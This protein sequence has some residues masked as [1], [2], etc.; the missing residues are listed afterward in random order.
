MAK[1]TQTQNRQ[2]PPSASLSCFIGEFSQYLASLV[3]TSEELLITGNFNIHVDNVKNAD[4]QNFLNSLDE[5]G[6]KQ[7]VD[8]PT[9]KRGHILDLVI[10]RESNNLLFSKPEVKDSLLCDLRGNVSGDHKG[11]CTVLNVSKPEKPEKLVSSRQFREVNIKD[12][13]SDLDDT[14]SFLKLDDISLDDHVT[15]Y[16]SI[17]R[18]VVDKHAPLL[19]KEITLRP[20][21]KWYSSELRKAKREKRKVKGNKINNIRDELV[22]ESRGDTNYMAFDKPFEGEELVNFDPTTCE[23]VLKILSNSAPKTC[24]LDPLPTNLLKECES[25]VLVPHITDIINKSIS[26]CSVPSSF[27]EAVV[28]PLLKKQGLDKECFKNYRPV[29]N[30][31]FISKVLEKVFAIR[32]DR[33]LEQNRLNDDLQSAYRKYHSTETALLRVHHDIA[34]ALDNNSCAVLVMLDL[35][36]AFDVIDHGILYK[37]LAHTFVCCLNEIKSWMSGNMLKL[38]E[39]KTDLIVFAP[40]SRIKTMTEFS[41]SFGEKIIHSVPN[42]TSIQQRLPRPIENNK[43]PNPASTASLQEVED[44]ELTAIRS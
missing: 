29:S 31:P 27:K 23:E 33:H 20:N 8:E 5:F 14:L 2:R 12:L 3:V 39:D 35:S 21:T 28:K 4:T 38:N 6:L 25:S 37:R 18:D 32:I 24:C 15:N 40:K 44:R 7:H 36:A 17:V 9:H 30:L 16:D 41:L 1:Y 43:M 10:T 13:S 34:A 19:S 22:S 42:A 11:I 26:E